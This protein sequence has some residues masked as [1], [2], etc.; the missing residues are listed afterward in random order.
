MARRTLSELARIAGA[1]L[2][3]DGSIAIEGTASLA[4]ASPSEISFC[5]LARYAPQLDSTRAAAVVVSP[6][7]R[8]RRRGLPL[9][10]H[11][12]PNAA[13]TRICAEFA[14]QRA[15]PAA[16][17]HAAAHVD[18][19]VEL[20][21]GVSVGAGA[22]VA[23]GVRLGARCVLHP[24][25]HVGAGCALGADCEL[26]PGVVL[27]EGVTLGERVIVHA[28]SVLGSDGFGY[29]PPTA[30]GGPWTKIPQSGRVEIGDD[31]EIGAGCTIDRGRFGATRLERGVKLD[32]Q[33]HIA[34][35]CVIGAGSMLA[36]QVGLA[37]STTV[38]R[39]VLLAGQCGISGHI[40]IGDGA[41][42]GGGSVVIGDVAPGED[43]WGYPARPRR[44]VLRQ[45]A[46]ARRLHELR[47]RVEALE[48]R[49]EVQTGA[50]GRRAS[51]ERS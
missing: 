25:V 43:V 21:P 3:G 37:G 6:Q 2:E 14:A 13:F 41:R 34:H 36:A 18:P 30:K 5:A 45:M 20:G 38:G 28:A 40:T 12:D 9:L 51:E 4:D 11:A 49:L 27:Y 16:G 10:V 29:E 35:N 31:V 32:N 19:G 1:A 22:T 50:P 44:E 42:C 24:G 8:T 17:V 26:H 46:E 33:V 48:R 47:E 15:R 7:M 23:A 39:G